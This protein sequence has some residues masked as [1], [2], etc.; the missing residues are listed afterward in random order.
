V[1]FVEY[2]HD[3]RLDWTALFGAHS[4]LPYCCGFRSV[5]TPGLRAI[6][7]LGRAQGAGRI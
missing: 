4:D 1:T 3:E 2:E 5:A 7:K 6:R